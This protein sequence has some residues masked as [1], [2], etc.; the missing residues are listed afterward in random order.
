MDHTSLGFL[1]FALEFIFIYILLPF[2]QNKAFFFSFVPSIAVCNQLSGQT[3][4]TCRGSQEQQPQPRP[5]DGSPQ[6]WYPPSVLS[7][8][9]S[10]RPGT[11]GSTSSSSFSSHRPTDRPQSPSHVSPAEAAGIIAVLKDKRL[12]PGTGRFH[13]IH[14]FILCSNLID[15]FF[16][17]CY[18]E[19]GDFQSV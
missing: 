18:L 12:V 9:S 2:N 8:P 16:F 10:S 11:P 15:F 19:D 4:S 1:L 13:F 7:S 14:T 6:S 3:I 17:F 5:Q